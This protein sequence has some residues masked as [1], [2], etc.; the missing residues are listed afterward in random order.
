MKKLVFLVLS[1]T[2]LAACT[3]AQ[4]SATPTPAA[5]AAPAA[6]STPAPSQTPAPT[7]TPAATLSAIQAAVA[8]QSA[9][10][11]TAQ[12]EAIAA[13]PT[14]LPM[15][16]D[17]LQIS[18]PDGKIVVQFGL[19][20]GVPYYRI[21]RAGQPVLLPSKMG[22]VFLTDK[23]LNAGLSILDWEQSTFDETWT[24]PW[25]EVKEIRDHHNELR[26]RLTDGGAEPRELIVV[27]RVFDDGVGFRYEFPEQP[28]LGEFQIMDEQTEFA[29]ADDHTTWWIG[30]YLENRYEYLYRQS[31]LSVLHKTAT[32]TVHTPLTMQT[33]AGL[34][35]SIHEAALVNYSSMTLRADENLT[36]HADLVP[37]S[38]G[39]RVR[40]STPLKTP[41]RTIQIAENPGDL[42]TSYLILNLNEPNK[43]GDVSW[44]Q[45]GKYIG[46]WWG[47][48]LDKWT[49]GSGPNHGATTANTQAYLDFAARY[50]FA[51]VL[52]E[53]WNW[54]WDGNWAASGD[55]FLFTHAH[56]D[57]DL[58]YLAEYAADLGV[59]IIGHHET[60][61]AVRN[62]ELQLEDAFALYQSLGINTVKTGYV[63]YGQGIARYD[64]NGNLL[65]ME[66]HHGQ[67]MV[68][69]YQLVAETAARYGIMIDTHEPIK[70]TG[71][72]RTYPNFMT[73]EGARGQEYNAW[74]GQGGNPPDHVA[75]LPFTRLLSGPMDYTPGVLALTYPEYRPNNRVNH[76]L[77]KELALYVVIYSPLQMA[78]DLIENYE[79]N[80]AFQF[81]LD[82]PADWHET[83][84]LHAA[85]GDYITTVR[86]ARDGDEWFL[87]SL[88]DE[89][90]RTLQAALTFLTPGVTYVAELYADAP[91]ADWETNPY[92]LEIRKVLVDATTVIDLI[93]APGGGQAIRFYPASAE[94]ISSLP[95]Y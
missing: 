86:R 10:Q 66:W 53:G 26:I 8:T 23:P 45:P 41:W 29:L 64:E 75:I 13:R 78:A 93:L 52:V 2:L 35:L 56:P 62:Y 70:D 89:N 49:W 46:I 21:D 80:P 33:A 12:A 11:A 1:L 82:V 88:T 94:E 85:I 37:W 67:Y 91:G 79:G 74:D 6:T 59:T 95:E 65:G 18:S 42:I 71:L 15:P 51:G 50:G 3:Q 4:I 83:L 9:A 72:R 17:S 87:G 40:G 25:G 61:A 27:F 57:F 63:G 54:G 58:E 92:A 7:A 39:V 60:G 68:Q 55:D 73:R 34:Y 77:A 81:I 24:Q 31:P 20:G 90:P 44:V 30:A 28:N 43:L 38:D 84:V 16:A 47:M 19:I 69:H 32:G 36:L 5:T 22:F 48:H 76:T 14:P